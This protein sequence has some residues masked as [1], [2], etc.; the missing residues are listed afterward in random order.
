[1]KR[2]VEHLDKLALDVDNQRSLGGFWSLL[3]V[4]LPTLDDIRG[5]NLKISP[6]IEYKYTLK[7]SKKQL[8][9]QELDESKLLKEMKR[10]A[11][12]LP[13]LFKNYDIS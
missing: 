6:I 1:M 7:N 13:S 2:F 8:V 5:R 4:E 11:E 12:I 3:F 9:A 10:W